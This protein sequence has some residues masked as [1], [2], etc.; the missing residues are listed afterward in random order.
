MKRDDFEIWLQ[1]VD[2]ERRRWT[3]KFRPMT[4]G[5]HAITYW[6]KREIV[7]NSRRRNRHALRGTIIHEAQHVAC[8]DIVTEAAVL[9]TE[10]NAS[11]LLDACGFGTG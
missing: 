5:E 2:G 8:G 3:V 11:D 7:I 4:K 6:Y 10:S 1:E 9:R